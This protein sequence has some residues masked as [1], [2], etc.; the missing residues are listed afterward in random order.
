MRLAAIDIG[1]NAVRCLI[2]E[3]DHHYARPL[4]LKLLRIP[5]RL[6]MDTFTRGRISPKKRADLIRTLQIYQLLMEVYEVEDYRA[7]ATSAVRDAAN[8]TEIVTEIREL[9]GIQIEVIDGKEE[10]S[11][12][13]ETHISQHLNPDR[14]YLYIDVGGGSTDVTLFPRGDRKVYNSFNI[15]TVRLMMNKVDPAEWERLR[16]WLASHTG[17]E[18]LIGVGSG[19]NINTIFQLS[20]RKSGALLSYEFISG[21]CREINEMKL[22]ERMRKY[23]LKPDRADVIGHACKIFTSIMEWT[24]IRKMK[25][26]QIG[27][28][29][30]IIQLLAEKHGYHPKGPPVGLRNAGKIIE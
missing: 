4:K 28:A 25:V 26:P 6:G 22:T 9:T 15:G 10:A 16:Q 12:V 11:I 2:S 21:F 18:K 24:G 7:C 29:D 17:G 20:R 30:G 14:S 19:G 13:F 5:L 3:V 23:G 8:A 27:L 1:S